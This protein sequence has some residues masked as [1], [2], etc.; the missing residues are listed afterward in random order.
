MPVTGLWTRSQ[1]VSFQIGDL[2][3]RKELKEKWLGS[4]GKGLGI[5]VGIGLGIRIAGSGGE[6]HHPINQSIN[7]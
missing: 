6:V 2:K 5:G 1:D 4:D 7:Q 3:L